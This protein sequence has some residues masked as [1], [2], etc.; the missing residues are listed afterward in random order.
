[1]SIL[2]K[3]SLQVTMYFL[4][5][6]AIFHI[7]AISKIQTFMFL[8][9]YHRYHEALN[10]VMPVDV[11]YGRDQEALTRRE[12]SKENYSASSQTKLY[13]GLNN[14]NKRSIYELRISPSV[15]LK[16]SKF[17]TE[18]TDM[19]TFTFSKKNSFRLKNIMKTMG[20]YAHVRK[21]V[22]INNTI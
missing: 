17:N 13:L 22:F 5:E 16:K 20:S 4:P 18:K 8:K 2:Y 7:P 21:Q 14:K 9:N 12:K 3:Q 6:R 11:Y 1:M 10:N 19:N 15:K